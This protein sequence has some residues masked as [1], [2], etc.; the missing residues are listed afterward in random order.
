[1]AFN[2]G[3]RDIENFAELVY[4]AF[5]LTHLEVNELFELLR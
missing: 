5:H 2:E 3:F 4:V 1:M